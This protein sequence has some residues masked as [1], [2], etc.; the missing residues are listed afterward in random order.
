VKP[1][2]GAVRSHRSVLLAASVGI[3]S[4]AFL[5][6]Y[7]I[8]SY[9]LFGDRA[10]F[11]CLG[12]F[13]LRGDSIYANS[14][15]GYPPIGPLVAA[16]AMALGSAFEIP[17][18]LGPRYAALALAA[19]DA[20]LL[21]Q[22]A[23][24]ATD[25]AGAGLVAALS[26][27]G[28]SWFGALSVS[29]LEPKILIVAL[30]LASA[31]CLQAR[32]DGQAGLWSALAALCWQPAAI[33]ALAALLV[34]VADRSAG[35][36]R[37]LVRFALGGCAAIV[38]CAI[39]L[40][41][42]SSW[43]DFADRL[44]GIHVQSQFSAPAPSLRWIEISARAYANELALL[45]SAAA[46][47]LVFAVRAARRG[48]LAGAA[49]TDR[50]LGAMPLM[51]FG[52]IAYAS[53]DFQ[54]YPDLLPLLPVGAFFV[55]WLAASIAASITGGLERLGS[56]DDRARSRVGGLV[57]AVLAGSVAVYGL[58]D[59]FRY[60]ADATLGAQTDAVA[61]LAA[62]GPIVSFGADSV[63]AL[64]GQKPPLPFLRLTD[65]FARHLS[66]VGM[67]DC[68]SVRDRLIAL[69]PASILVASN[70]A[71]HCVAMIESQ[72]K[73]AGYEPSVRSWYVSTHGGSRTPTEGLVRRDWRVYRHPD[74][75][76]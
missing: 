69:E 45:V 38:P 22:I 41:A 71:G 11:V 55:G 18:H 17:T 33:V 10:Y 30:T 19:L 1:V 72:A 58:H 39:Y 28:F 12:Q 29:S 25:R 9:P 32:R 4:A 46:G 27:V 76:P 14:F 67:R 61:E 54:G 57:L 43:G 62:A 13:V 31:A 64:S 5:L 66:L 51:A 23:R 34:V 52:W 37:R 24:R 48:R 26:L 21:F 2:N 16:A 6:G 20:G 60:E 74:P 70:G 40:T 44:L 68:A 75:R 59:I 35:F 15:F 3:A 8:Q 47:L 65:L 73:A 42:T 49:L 63:Y 50:R 7:G 53:F 56:A 36:T